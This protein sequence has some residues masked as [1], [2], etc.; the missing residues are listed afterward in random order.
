MGGGYPPP[1]V[2]NASPPPPLACASPFPRTSA[3]QTTASASPSHR[4]GPGAQ[5]NPEPLLPRMTSG[6]V[7]PSIDISYTPL[8]STPALAGLFLSLQ[9]G[10]PEPE[11]CAR[12]VSAR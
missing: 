7:P 6:V 11:V 10:R 4:K 5:L 2:C 12:A 9:Y 3:P 8:S 1:P